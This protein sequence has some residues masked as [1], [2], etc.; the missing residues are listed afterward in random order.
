MAVAVIVATSR[1]N[2]D[3]VNASL[4]AVVAKGTLA[5]TTPVVATELHSFLISH[6]SGSGFLRHHSQPPP[7]PWFAVHQVQPILPGLLTKVSLKRSNRNF[8]IASVWSS[9]LRST[10]CRNKSHPGSCRRIEATQML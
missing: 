2:P 9:C 7:I 5:V 6:F 4:S 10:Q 3:Q 1:W 8:V